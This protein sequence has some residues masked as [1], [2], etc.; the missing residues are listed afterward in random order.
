M[1]VFL[2]KND[3]PLITRKYAEK[4]FPEFVNDFDKTLKGVDIGVRKIMTSVP[5]PTK[6][7]RPYTRPERREGGKY[8]SV[9][10]K[11]VYKAADLALEGKNKLEI[12]HE[13]N[14]KILTV[15]AYLTIARGKGFLPKDFKVPD[16]ISR[17]YWKK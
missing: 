2:V 12:A 13:L 4:W 7:D 11:K 9:N 1:V 3:F 10:L 14:I 8:Y 15:G 5:R 17:N 16:G 6:K